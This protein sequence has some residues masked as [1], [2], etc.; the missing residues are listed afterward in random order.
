MTEEIL[1]DTEDRMSK[2][3]DAFE[4]E[5]VKIRTG[6]ATTNLVDGIKVDYYGAETP[7]NQ[8]ASISIPDQRTIAI[9][10]WEK[11][12]IGAVEKA[13]L[14]SDIGITPNNDGTFIRLNIPDLTGERRKDLVRMVKKIT[15]DYR[16]AV[17]NVRRDANDQLK[18]A[19]KASEISEDDM[20]RSQTKVQDLTDEY[21]K[22][23]DKILQDKETEIMEE[24]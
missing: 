23:I 11:G 1:F 4:R 10:P 7:L 5:L 19:E 24:G 2:S 12:I 22:Q 21:I 15:E 3:V 18:K 9:Q 20:K 6:R 14:K 8:V 17:R 16:V 13:I